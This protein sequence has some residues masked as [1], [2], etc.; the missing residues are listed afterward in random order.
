MGKGNVKNNIVLISEY[1]MPEEFECIWEKKTTT[2]I[3]LGVNENSNRTR[4]E[5][6]YKPK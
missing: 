6:L 3:G 1:N 4:I 2:L 5:R